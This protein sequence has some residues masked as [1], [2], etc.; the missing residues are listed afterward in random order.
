MK[1]DGERENTA[2][3]ANLALNGVQGTWVKGSVFSA[4]G[5]GYDVITANPPYWPSEGSWLC[6]PSHLWVCLVCQVDDSLQ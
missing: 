6:L 5:R 1:I 3:Q 2:V 4:V